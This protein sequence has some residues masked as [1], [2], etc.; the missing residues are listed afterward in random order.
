MKMLWMYLRTALVAWLM[1]QSQR[2][3]YLHDLRRSRQ[4]G[5]VR[6]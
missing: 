3:N 4:R 1:L 6:N 2:A 5:K